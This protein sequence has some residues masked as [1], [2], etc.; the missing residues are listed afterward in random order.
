VRAGQ[1]CTILVPV[2]I[3]RGV[4][5]L[6][7]VVAGA[8]AGC[9]SSGNKGLIGLEEPS[10]ASQ[11][12]DMADPTPSGGDDGGSVTFVPSDSGSTL[13]IG[14]GS[15]TLPSNFVKT[16]H[17]GYALG[18]AIMGDGADAGVAE[19]TGSANC[20]LVVGVVRDFKNQSDDND[21][22]DPDFGTF[23]GAAPTTG[24]VE[25]QLGTDEKPV[26][27]GKCMAGAAFSLDCLTGPQM[28][29]TTTFNEW[30][31]YTPGVNK[32]Y[33]VYL[34]FVPNAGVYTFESEEY[35][36]L[37]DAGWGNN[38]QGDDGK[39]HNFGFTTELH[40]K[41]TYNGGEQFTFVGDDDVWVFIN[42]KLAVD[43]GGLHSAATGTVSLDSLSLTKGQDYPLDLFQAERK[44]TG[45]HFRADTDLAFT[46]CGTIPPDIPQ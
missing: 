25:T 46:S 4:Q 16:E 10:D 2:K 27:T 39:E 11:S 5:A 40:L 8:L 31:R 43:L 29:S 41:F 14:D 13:P 37:D 30:Y 19:N 28:T 3:P 22:G 45:S 21:T 26:Y 9:G 38:A 36:P 33:L 15:V 34:Q 32:P 44:P 42:G 23:S 12:D 17:G 35:F 24:L 20:S 6:G 7:C 18:P 1:G